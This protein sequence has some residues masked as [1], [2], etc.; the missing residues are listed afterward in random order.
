MNPLF[1]D[2]PLQAKTQGIGGIP[3]ASVKADTLVSE[4]LPLDQQDE[5]YD[6]MEPFVCAVFASA[7]SRLELKYCM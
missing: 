7:R 3:R 2:D 1:I 5:A 6:A 4:C